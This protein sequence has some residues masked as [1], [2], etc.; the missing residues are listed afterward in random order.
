MIIM[1]AI[2]YYFSAHIPHL[3]VHMRQSTA[4]QDASGCNKNTSTYHI[5][6]CTH[7]RQP[8][9]CLVAR[10]NHTIW[11][12]CERCLLCTQPAQCA[13][14]EVRRSTAHARAPACTLRCAT[15]ADNDN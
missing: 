14:K 3:H 15:N 6:G 5:Q 10:M 4:L 9:P 12:K 11:Y 2:Y 7:T 1:T 8:L 13:W